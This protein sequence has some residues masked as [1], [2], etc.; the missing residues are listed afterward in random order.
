MPTG[1][2]KVDNATG[3]CL[4]SILG[5]LIWFGVIALIGGIIS[6]FS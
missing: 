3:G 5:Y 6:L 4:G 1:F 2:E